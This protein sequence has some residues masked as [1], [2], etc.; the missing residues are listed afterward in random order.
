MTLGKYD[1]ALTKALPQ[2]MLA[3]KVVQR[4]T[5]CR[6]VH[7]ELSIERMEDLTFEPYEHREDVVYSSIF[8]N[9]QQANA[10][11]GGGWGISEDPA[12]LYLEMI[13][14]PLKNDKSAVIQNY[15][16]PA[17]VHAFPEL[18]DA[19]QMLYV[20]RKM[21]PPHLSR[22][23]VV[24][25]VALRGPLAAGTQ[26][27]AQKYASVVVYREMRIIE[28]H[29]LYCHGLPPFVEFHPVRAPWIACAP[30]AEPEGERELVSA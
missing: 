17:G 15:A 11:I 3:Y 30:A 20:A 25:R 24:V 13:L 4:R 19:L 10:P 16:Y 7:K 26:V 21:E 23:F 29:S 1:I 12:M 2:S 22:Q 9:Q 18:R 8:G 28:E 6:F 14:Y 5:I 27:I